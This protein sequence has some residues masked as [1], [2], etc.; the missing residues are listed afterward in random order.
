MARVLL[1][2]DDN[3]TSMILA[4]AIRKAGH[5]VVVAA[6]GLEAI[7][8]L[9][10]TDFS[11]VISDLMMPKMSGEQLAKKI[12]HELGL[13]ELPILVA[14]GMI[15]SDRLR[16]IEEVG[17]AGLVEKPVKLGALLAKIA[18]LEEG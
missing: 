2:E 4:R 18:A 8:C 17:H 6:N 14:T 3:V 16:W 9:L 7:D 13:T 12:R 11:L 10:E 15:D 1:V 5:E